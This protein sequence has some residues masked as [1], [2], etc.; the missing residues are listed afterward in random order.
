MPKKTSYSRNK[1][2][3]NKTKQKSFEL[4]R[5]TS[6]NAVLEPVEE[7]NKQVNAVREDA[8]EVEEIEETEEDEEE[9]DEDEEELAKEGSSKKLVLTEQ[10]AT[11]GKKIEASKKST[12]EVPV[13]ASSGSK[14]AVARM[15]AR[16]QAA[17]KNQRSSANLILAENYAYVR[18]DLI[19]ILILAIVLFSI[20]V[21]LHFVPAI[22]G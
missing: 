21:V 15:N 9:R 11:P 3:R 6:G 14:S 13:A 12:P 2:Q 18:K 19:F 22:G 7:D 8:P 17:Q 10:K 16:R 20:I 5:P 1:A 4:V